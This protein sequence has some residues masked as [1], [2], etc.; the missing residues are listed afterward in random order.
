MLYTAKRAITELYKLNI[1]DPAGCARRMAYLL[2]G[3]RF[4]CPPNRY[5]VSLFNIAGDYSDPRKTKSN[6]EDRL[7]LLDS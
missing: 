1:E 2:E 4:I 3:D 7:L 6:W 5:E